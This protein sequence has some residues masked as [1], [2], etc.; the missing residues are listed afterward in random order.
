MI[1]FNVLKYKVSFVPSIILSLF[2]C[3]FFYSLYL[4]KS[5]WL[6]IGFFVLSLFLLLIFIIL[7]IKRLIFKNIFIFCSCIIFALT[8]SSIAYVHFLILNMPVFTLAKEKKIEKITF[9]LTSD[10]HPVGDKYYKANAKIISCKTKEGNAYSCEGNVLVFFP[11]VLIRQN[12]AGHNTLKK[13]I[14]GITIFYRGM[15]MEAEGRFSLKRKDE[16]LLYSKSAFFVLSNEAP[17]FLGWKSLIY[18][19]RANMRFYLNRM[20]YG[21]NKAGYLLLALLS[22]N[23]DFL[24]SLE[25]EAFRNAGL[26]HVLALSGMHLSIIGFLSAFFASFLFK[27]KILKIF[28]V[29]ACF[30]F[31]VFVGASPS[32][33][34]A[35]IM[36]SIIA[37]AKIMY[38]KV[39]LLGV[40]ALSFS[41]HLLLFPE[42]AFTLSFL[43]SYSALFGILMF[44]NIFINFFNPFVPDALNSSLSTSLAATFSTLPIVAVVF[45]R[46]C[47]IGVASTCIISPLISIF[48]V[49]GI[50]SIFISLFAPLL[51]E[52]LGSFLNFFFELIINIV[53]L[54]SNIPMLRLENV[55]WSNFLISLPLIF[56]FLLWFLNEKKKLSSVNKL[57]N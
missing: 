11:S 35:F 5:K 26:S 18:K 2:L 41:F 8:T 48:L 38:V 49:F 14:D 46:V 13:D 7:K 27:R 34:R 9:F 52:P 3:C 56:L 19:T 33:I 6:A 43:L 53:Y 25:I 50:I 20:L 32:L 42:D 23:K 37:I 40:L 17:K 24:D 54:F 51:Y 39:N 30:C 29:L 31:L 22:G 57:F 44:S 36:L 21:W 15:K 47:F 16:M 55:F 12:Y 4:F 1:T 45:K 28:I 10:V